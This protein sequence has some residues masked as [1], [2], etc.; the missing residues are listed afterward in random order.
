[1]SQSVL[2]RG[3]A[4]AKQ[5]DIIRR[6]Y[7]FYGRVQGVGFRYSARY[8]AMELGLTG[9]VTNEWDGSVEMEVQGSE[10]QIQKLLDMLK[11]RPYISIEH[12]EE[13][14]LMPVYTEQKFKIH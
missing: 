5:D 9:W 6:H 13:R 7:A 4:M 1:M 14:Q 11:N 12:M 3:I 10:E 2:E 8:A